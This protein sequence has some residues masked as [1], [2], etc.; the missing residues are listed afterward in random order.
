MP[1]W[2]VWR[3]QCVVLQNLSFIS[4]TPAAYRVTFFYLFYSFPRLTLSVTDVEIDLV[5]NTNNVA[6]L[7]PLET[8][9]RNESSPGTTGRFTGA[10]LEE[11]ACAAPLL[12][13]VLVGLVAPTDRS[14][15]QTDLQFPHWD[16]AAATAQEYQ[17]FPAAHVQV[18]A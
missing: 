11:S 4:S 18:M 2:V 10:H 15:M 1:Q 6:P 17:A 13:P 7:T 16:V 5:Y 3:F 12:P 9:L 14:H 8:A